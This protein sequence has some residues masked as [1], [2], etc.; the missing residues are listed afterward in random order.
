MA[1]FRHVLSTATERNYDSN[2]ARRTSVNSEMAWFYCSSW[3]S[4]RDHRGRSALSD[5]SITSQE[6]SR[7]RLPEETRSPSDWRI[8]METCMLSW[9]WGSEVQMAGDEVFAVE[10][11]NSMS[12]GFGASTLHSC[13]PFLMQPQHELE[14]RSQVC[15]EIHVAIFHRHLCRCG[16]STVP[17]SRGRSNGQHGAYCLSAMIET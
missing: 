1:I 11:R 2:P 16:P 10:G 12:A 3:R 5:W 6:R 14:L 4:C 8:W 13:T 17:S 7:V 15:A 9:S